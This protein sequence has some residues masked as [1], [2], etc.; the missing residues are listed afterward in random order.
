MIVYIVFEHNY[1]DSRHHGVFTT[2]E[3]AE[4]YVLTYCQTATPPKYTVN[5][6][7]DKVE[8]Q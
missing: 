6:D 4:Q 1:E 5:F 3:K 2:Q 7:I 8:V